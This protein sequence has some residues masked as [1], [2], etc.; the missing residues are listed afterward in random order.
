MDNYMPYGPGWEKEMMKWDKKS[1]IK[2]LGETLDKVN[3]S[4]NVKCWGELVLTLQSKADWVNNVPRKLPE[5]YEFQ[6]LIW[7][8][9]RGFTL[10]SGVDFEAA[11]QLRYYPVKCYRAILTSE[12]LAD[13]EKGEE[14][15]NQIFKL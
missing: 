9:S 4:E 14:M 6:T 3:Q 2:L 10:R 11:E 1:L 5:G 12:R 8:D 13:V 15:F 7:V